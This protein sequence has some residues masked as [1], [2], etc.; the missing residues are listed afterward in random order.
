MSGKSEKN[1]WKRVSIYESSNRPACFISPPVVNDLCVVQR[2]GQ[3][4]INQA[5]ELLIGFMET[6]GDKDPKPHMNDTEVVHYG[7]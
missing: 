4:D 3:G 7:E 2:G 1:P 5:F 6:K